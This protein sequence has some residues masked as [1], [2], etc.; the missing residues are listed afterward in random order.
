MVTHNN[1]VKMVLS[2]KSE[3]LEKLRLQQGMHTEDK[4][5]RV[6]VLF[7]LSLS[8]FFFFSLKKKKN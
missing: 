7:F 6:C 1:A 3:E 5:L 8:N 4:I 2:G